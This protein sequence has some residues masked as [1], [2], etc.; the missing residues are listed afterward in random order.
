MAD[1]ASLHKN[2]GYINGR[3]TKFTN[4]LLVED[5]HKNIDEIESRLSS[6]ETHFKTLTDIQLKI[7]ELAKDENSLDAEEN[8]VNGIEEAYFSL[9]AKAR[10]LLRTHA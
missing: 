3:I 9:V 1:I 2:R 10:R 7:Q 6:V 5:N 8:E 4:F